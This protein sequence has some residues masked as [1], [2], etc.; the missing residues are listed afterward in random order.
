MIV[1]SRPDGE[2]D[3]T[4]LGLIRQA[5]VPVVLVRAGLKPGGIAPE[6]TLTQFSWSLSER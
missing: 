1:L 5:T 6:R 4:R 3:P 2:L